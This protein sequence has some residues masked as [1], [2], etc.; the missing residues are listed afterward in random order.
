MRQAYV[1]TCNIARWIY[2]A[3]HCYCRTLYPRTQLS[4]KL[5]CNVNGTP[6]QD[7]AYLDSVQ[8]EYRYMDG[9]LV[10]GT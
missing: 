5:V 2:V 4:D 10:Q 1:C 9:V 3:L 8:L 6:P 7:I